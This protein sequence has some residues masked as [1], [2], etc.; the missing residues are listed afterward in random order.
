MIRKIIKRTLQFLGLKHKSLQTQ[1][2]ENG[3]KVGKN[4]FIGSGTLI[5]IDLAFLLEIG[6][7]VVIASRSI[8]ELHDSSLPNILGKGKLRVGKIIIEDNAYIGV[9]TTILSGLI[10]GKGALVGANSL[11][12]KSIP[13]GEVWAGVPA[14][15]ICKVTELVNK[16]SLEKDALFYD[17]D[18]IGEAEKKEINYP[19]YKKEMQN[20]VKQHYNYKL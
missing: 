14:K 19:V 20:K 16:R 13:A 18:W 4:T 1:I 5:D 9:A 3:G 17:I 11:V 7:G 15:Y 8:I 6:K 10:I 12:N 2:I